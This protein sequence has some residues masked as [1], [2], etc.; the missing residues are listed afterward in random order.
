[1]LIKTICA[2][3]RRAVIFCKKG[4]QRSIDH[5]RVECAVFPCDAAFH[6]ARIEA[7]CRDSHVVAQ[8]FLCA[9]VFAGTTVC[10]DVFQ[11]PLK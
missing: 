6:C 9:H 2:F 7:R 10:T 8:V 1:M 5:D 3:F 11:G 4:I